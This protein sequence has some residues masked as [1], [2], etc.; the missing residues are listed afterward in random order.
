[1]SEMK[2]WAKY[3]PK[4][5]QEVERL[6]KT[7]RSSEARRLFCVRAAEEHISDRI[8][9][10]VARWDSEG[11]SVV[12]PNGEEDWEANDLI[13]NAIA[14]ARAEAFSVSALEAPVDD[15]WWDDF[16]KNP[17]KVFNLEGTSSE[18]AVLED[19]AAHLEKMAGEECKAVAAT[20]RRQ[21]KELRKTGKRP[22]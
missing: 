12:G 3:D 10:K 2:E 18:A 22:R 15:T 17:T 19:H 5:A 20:L 13:A 11:N 6:K 8:D 9:G 16:R 4:Y 1:M 21:I 7:R 14:D